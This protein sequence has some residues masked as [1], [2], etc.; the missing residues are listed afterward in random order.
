MRFLIPII[1]LIISGVVFFGFIDTTYKEIKVMQAEERLFSEALDNSKELQAIRDDLLATYNSFS[2]EDIERLEKLLP[3][4]VDNV[5]LIRDIDGIAA[6]YG[7]SL[8]NVGLSIGNGESS[9]SIGA[10]ENVQGSLILDFSVVAPYRV[11][12]SFLQDLEKSL[13][14]VDV[15]QVG[16]S[17]A[18][19]DFYEYD[20]AIRT[21]WL[22]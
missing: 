18:D 5:R 20:V 19:K 6:K 1:V 11:F 13:R 2:S 4:N 21:Y 17:S 8:R 3:N 10:G 22:K 14:L 15:V 16:F 7:M 12:L 9:D